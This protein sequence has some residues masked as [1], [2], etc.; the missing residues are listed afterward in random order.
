MNSSGISGAV[1]ALSNCAQC[2]H[3]WNCADRR[4][5]EIVN[6]VAKNPRHLRGL[7]CY[8]PLRIGESLRWINE[9][10]TGGGTAGAYSQAECCISGLDA[11]RMYPLYGLCAML[12]AP[13]VLEITSGEDWTHHRPQVELVAADFPE[14]DIL[15]TPPPGT[16]SAG[17]I[18]LMQHFP[19]ISFLLCPVQL[20]A[21]AALCDYVELEGRERALFRSSRE[22]WPASV[23]AAC[24]VPLGA[25]ALRA[26]LYENATRLFK[27][28]TEAVARQS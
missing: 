25:T 23:E 24:A 16:D 18:E 17:M 3:R 6:T 19:R 12:R 15:L 1:L 14:L 28:P 9:A 26:Y 10:I 5:Q 11:P 7:A 21:D 13:V 8:D 2:Q 4:T 27:F 20:Q 22:G